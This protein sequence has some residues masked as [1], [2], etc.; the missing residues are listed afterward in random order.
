MAGSGVCMACMAGDVCS[1]GD[2][3]GRESCVAGDIGTEVGGYT[4]YYNA[5]LF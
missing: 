5:F 1:K 3:R 4:S 2:V